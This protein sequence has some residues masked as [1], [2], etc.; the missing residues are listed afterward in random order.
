MPRCWRCLLALQAL[1]FVFALSASSFAQTKMSA[2]ILGLD[3]DDA[4]RQADALSGALRTRARAQPGW[5]ISENTDSIALVTAALRCPSHP[6][7]T[8]EKHIGEQLKTDRFFWG[9]VRRIGPN[10]L[11]AEVHYWQK[12]KPDSS[13]REIFP[14]S[15]N[16]ATDPAAKAAA[17]HIFEKLTGVSALGGTLT[18][19]AGTGEG[20]VLVDGEQ[21]G[22]L[23]HGVAHI[24]LA[25]GPHDVEVRSSG[26]M[27][28]KQNVTVVAGNEA[29]VTMTLVPVAA[30]TEVPH[31]DE[32][33]PPPE[34]SS[35]HGK[36]RTIVG[37]ALIGLGVIAE[38]VAGYE[39]IQFL[40]NRSTWNG[41]QIQSCNNSSSGAP[42]TSAGGLAGCE[43]VTSRHEIGCPANGMRGA[44]FASADQCDAYDSAKSA[45]APGFIFAGAGVVL[46]GAGAVILLTA[47]K[48]SEAATSK[49]TMP[50]I[51]PLVGPNVAGMAA[52]FEF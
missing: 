14:D 36:G 43:G 24:D 39:G 21:K 20:A 17:A 51:T 37:L 11:S 5:T 23:D 12:G 34:T 33:K 48:S 16:V 42:G 44:P 41:Y 7:A 49:S 6:D 10:Q 18:V 15:A 1:L 30:T 9:N 46:A 47:P 29:Q 45:I 31:P 8:C 3:S 50:K 25:P 19:T 40:S 13:V 38:G 32:T 52:G 35:G 2:A 28:S 27:P 26:Y 22:S 4:E